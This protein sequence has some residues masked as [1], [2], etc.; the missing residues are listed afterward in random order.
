MLVH[1]GQC[2][3]HCS[4]LNSKWKENLKVFEKNSNPKIRSPRFLFKSLRALNVLNGNMLNIKELKGTSGS[5][6]GPFRLSAPHISPLFPRSVYFR[7]FHVHPSH[8]LP[9][10]RKKYPT[11]SPL[12]QRFPID[13]LS[14]ELCHQVFSDINSCV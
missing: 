11:F 10:I 13:G 9:S 2:E 6:V 4:I 5:P 7:S 12:R 1:F 8:L 3:H 14:P